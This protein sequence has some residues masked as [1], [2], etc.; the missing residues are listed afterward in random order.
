MYYFSCLGGIGTD[1]LKS[2]SGHDTLNLCFSIRWDLWVM[3]CI[4]VRLG[5]ET[6][7]HD[8]SCLGGTSVFSKNSAPVPVTLDLCFCFWWDLQ[9]T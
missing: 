4:R 5:N 2:M 1:S 7:M 9:V 6:F 8:F 3:Y